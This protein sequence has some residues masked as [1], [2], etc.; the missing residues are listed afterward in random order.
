M[1]SILKKLSYKEQS[2]VLIL[3]PPEEFSSMLKEFSSQVDLEIKGKYSFIQVFAVESKEANKLAKKVLKAI[4]DNALLWFCYPKGTSKK[5]KS[6][7]KRENCAKLFAEK[8]YEPVA[9]IAIDED[10][11]AMRF[12]PVDSIKTMKRKN[13]VSIK[14]KKRIAKDS[15]KK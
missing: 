4:G 13:A 6:D 3:N 7:L 10:W 9:Q 5:Y 15:K 12:K 1:N 11:S 8:N 14:G 2:P